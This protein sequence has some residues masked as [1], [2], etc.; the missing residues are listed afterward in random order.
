MG[1]DPEPDRQTRGSTPPAL[2]EGTQEA[3]LSE[4]TQAVKNPYATDNMPEG[5][6]LVK[7]IVVTSSKIVRR[8]MGKDGTATDKE[9]KPLI[10]TG[11]EVKGIQVGKDKEERFEFSAGK[12]GQPSPDGELLVDEQGAPAKVYQTSNF[13]KALFSLE[14]GGFDKTLLY[15]RISVIVGGRM[16]LEGRDKVGAD[17]KVKTHTYEGKTY[18]DIEWV[19]IGFVPGA[20][21]TAG[22]GSVDL[23]AKAEAAV[24]AAIAEAGGEIDRKDLIRALGTALKG[25]ADAVRITAMVARQ[26]FHAGRPWTFDGSKLTLGAE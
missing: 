5:G 11:W 9:G 13:G 2:F 20:A 22:N 16:T 8:Q 7:E 19:P 26:D 17:G 18:N 3:E 25:D 6:G 21:R 15:P 24:V 10:F 1:D 4:S 23:G 14:K 12:K